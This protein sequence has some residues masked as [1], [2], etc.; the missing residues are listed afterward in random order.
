MSKDVKNIELI[1]GVD[2]EFIQNLPNNGTKLLLVFDDSCEEIS[3]SKDFVEI[4][5]AGRHRGLS[6]IYNKHDFFHQRRL[7]R[8]IELQNTQIVWFKS[9]RDV[10][11]IITLSQQLGLDSQLKYWHTKATSIP[12]G[13]L[14]IDLTPKTFDSLQFWTNS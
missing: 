6:T 11:Q 10:L 9:P 5:T 4:A 14:L 1:E 12:Y 2:F 8:D 7:G 13:H 3:S